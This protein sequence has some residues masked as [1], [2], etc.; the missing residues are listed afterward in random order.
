LWASGL[1][2]K[3]PHCRTRAASLSLCPLA[4]TAEA[5]FW[6]K[7]STFA[8]SCWTCAWALATSAR[9]RV[10]CSPGK[11]QKNF[12]PEIFPSRTR[13]SPISSLSTPS[14][15]PETIPAFE[16]PLSISL[17]VKTSHDWWNMASMRSFFSAAET[18]LPMALCSRDCCAGARAGARAEKCKQ[19]TKTRRPQY[20]A[21]GG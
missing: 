16:A 9:F 7:A 1:G 4:L 12:D 5:A 10:R 18:P 15:A 3:L 14:T 21:G 6:R 11:L 2:S 17:E 13:S 19:T 20:S 8:A